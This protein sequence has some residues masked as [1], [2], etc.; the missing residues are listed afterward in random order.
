MEHVRYL[1]E[2]IG[3]RG[4]TT[5]KEREA[6]R[7]V[8]EQLRGMGFEPLEEPFTSAV[9]AW[10]PYVLLCGLVI[11]AELLF[12]FGGG[13]GTVVGILII[14]VSVV[15]VLLEL[16]FR[17]NPLRWVL[18]KGRSQ[19][20]W[21][22][23]PPRKEERRKV[24]VLAHVDSHRTPWIFSTDFLTKV[25]GTLVPL[26][27]VSVLLI[28][29]FMLGSLMAPG[30]PWRAVSL[31]PAAVVL[32]LF[33]VT[34]QADFSPYSPG[35]N[36]NASGVGV[37]LD[38]AERLSKEPL[39]HTA[40]W[41][42]F[43]G[44]EEV[45]CYGADAFARA[46][47]AELNRPIWIAVDSV[48]CYNSH[49]TYIT[50]E[51]FLLTTRSDPELVKLA[52]E[53]TK[54]R[55]ELKVRPHSFRGAYTEGAIGGKYGFRVITLG[56]IREDGLLPEWHRP[57]DVVERIDPDMLRRTGEFLWSLLRRIDGKLSEESL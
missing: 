9:S 5:E 14:V 16:A 24:V 57:T 44:C 12:L 15:S 49:P 39:E 19:N 11:L 56:S 54:A 35:A 41:V 53:V 25:F 45:G 42:V 4:S 2:T 52:E 23:V 20:V 46:H 38:V 29:G 43:S 30:L 8:A 32:A 55:P 34:L 22:K 27:L 31:V 26:G 1:A 51:T 21:V 47:R 37:V 48:G 40:V 13:M 6:S 17:P 7:Y 10:Y 33:G 18:P 28:M 3:P 50:A 36:D